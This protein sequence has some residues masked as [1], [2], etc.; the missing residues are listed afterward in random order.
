MKRTNTPYTCRSNVQKHHTPAGQTYKHAIH[1]PVKRTN[2]PYTCRSNV[3]TRHTPAGQTY[4]HAIYLSVKRTNTPYT[5]RSNVQTIVAMIRLSRYRS[6]V[7]RQTGDLAC[8]R[9]GWHST[10][11]NIKGD[12]RDLSSMQAGT[13]PQRLCSNNAVSIERSNGDTHTK[14]RQQTLSSQ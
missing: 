13:S 7:Q 14:D 5:C 12:I 10:C 11:S 4:K 3:Q 2:T 6:R 1:L 8:S 9:L